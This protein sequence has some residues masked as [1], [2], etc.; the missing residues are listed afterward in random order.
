MKFE[1]TGGV[2]QVRGGLHPVRSGFCDPGLHS[3]VGSVRSSSDQKET[4]GQQNQCKALFCE[5]QNSLVLKKGDA[6][7][8][9]L[10][11]FG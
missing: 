7:I 11:L 6:A 9:L 4:L 8:M 3:S 10:E 1:E 2:P 5:F